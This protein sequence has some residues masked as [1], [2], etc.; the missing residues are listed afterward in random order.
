MKE[1]RILYRLNI[2]F[3]SCDY[4]APLNV[5]GDEIEEITLNGAILRATAKAESEPD[6]TAW[7]LTA[8]YFPVNGGNAVKSEIIYQI[9]ESER[10]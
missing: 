5:K 7:Q 4:S 9:G 10:L 3:A 6:F 2:A 1:Y 8:H